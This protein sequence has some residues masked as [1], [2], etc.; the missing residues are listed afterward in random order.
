M[1]KFRL[2]RVLDLR[3]RKERDAA[4]A[5]VTAEEH[6]DGARQERARLELARQ[7]LAARGTPRPA[8]QA[9]SVGELRNI[10]FLLERLD[11]RVAV[12]ATEAAAAEAA[13]AERRGELQLAFRDR[14]TLDRLKERHLEGY[15]AAEAAA[16]RTLMDEI[17]LTRFTQG[18]AHGAAGAT[19]SH[20]HDES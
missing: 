7:E 20:T 1:F 6:A 3:E 4:T 9:R 12:A 8:T 10:G 18:G 5:L 15:R 2:Q 14:R 13:V 19:G 16:D 17:A 11:E